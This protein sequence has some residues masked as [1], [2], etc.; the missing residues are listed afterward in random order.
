MNNEIKK[1]I[2]VSEESVEPG[3]KEKV[4]KRITAFLQ[5][6]KNVFSTN[7]NIFL[8]LSITCIALTALTLL[9]LVDG[10]FP[11]SKMGTVGD[12][13]SGLGSFSVILVMLYQQ[14]SMK[15][16]NKAQRENEII[17]GTS[18][19]KIEKEFKNFSTTVY[20]VANKGV[21]TYE[22]MELYSVVAIDKNNSEIWSIVSYPNDIISA[23]DEISF[24][25]KYSLTPNLIDEN[26][27]F[28]NPVC[29]YE[30]DVPKDSKYTH[31]SFKSN[32]EYG[33]KELVVNPK[34]YQI[35]LRLKEVQSGFSLMIDANGKIMRNEF[36]PWN[37]PRNSRNR[38]AWNSLGI[39][40]ETMRFEDIF[41]PL[42]SLEILS[43][44]H[45]SYMDT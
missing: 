17:E 15:E 44:G 8:I 10:I 34:A 4:N 42:Y 43:S 33:L 30:F 3:K 19:I 2:T 5:K 32:A 18:K 14:R 20:S 13:L 35:L 21:L 40:E 45:K 41:G 1:V 12:W 29:E 31:I 23:Y 11:V 24:R 38:T 25:T 9:T 39:I 22:L 27:Y 37:E 26:L 6:L 16:E 28:D 7:L 36:A